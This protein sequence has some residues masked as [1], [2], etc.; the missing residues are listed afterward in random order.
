MT[1]T[2]QHPVFCGGGDGDGGIK[3]KKFW[4]EKSIMHLFWGILLQVVFFGSDVRVCLVGWAGIGDYE[5]H[6]ILKG[7]LKLL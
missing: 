1:F 5:L 7:Q 3:R 6:E 4:V 2:F